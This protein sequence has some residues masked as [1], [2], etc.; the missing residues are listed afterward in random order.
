MVR[1]FGVSGTHRG[2][3][4]KSDLQVK[5]ERGDGRTATPLL[6]GLTRAERFVTRLAVRGTGVVLAATMRAVEIARQERW[7]FVEA[8]FT[9]GGLRMVIVPAF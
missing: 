4:L 5:N 6:F 7:K 2:L 3:N 9:P 8:P 1:P